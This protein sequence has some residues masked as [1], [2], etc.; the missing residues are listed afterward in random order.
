MGDLIDVIPLLHRVVDDSL[1]DIVADHGTGH[2]FEAQRPEALVDI[3]SCLLQIESLVGKLMIPWET[4]ST[5]GAG[6]HVCN[7]HIHRVIIVP[8]QDNVNGN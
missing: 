4:K 7:L 3:L 1:F 8:G 5:Y 2:I 6:K